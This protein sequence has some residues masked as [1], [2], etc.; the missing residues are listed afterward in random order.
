MIFGEEDVMDK[1]IIF[2]IYDFVS[3]HIGSTLL[4]KGLEVIGIHIDNLEETGNLEEKRLEI[5]RNANFNEI[6]LSKLDGYKLEDTV[7][8]TLFVS[9]Y[10]LYMLNRETILQTESG[11]SLQQFIDNNHVTEI[12][13]ILPIQH[14]NTEPDAVL[15]WLRGA[16]IEWQFVYLPAVYGPWQP[17]TFSFQQ[18]LLARFEETE[19]TA[20]KREWTGDILFI[21]D[22]VE[23]ILEIIDESGLRSNCILIESGIEDYWIQCAAQLKL[24]GS[25]TESV[26]PEPVLIDQTIKRVTVKHVTPFQES[27]KR[28]LDLL[29]RI[30]LNN[31]EQ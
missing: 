15:Q 23:A 19:I 28:Q 1:A 11:K 27:I 7:K 17:P 25:L 18:A 6:S 26:R 2:G 9:L 13:S 24:K 10:D 5:G 16:P 3:F 31:A 12:V 30:N 4:N 14:L 8:T 29:G 22:A 21:D 20:N